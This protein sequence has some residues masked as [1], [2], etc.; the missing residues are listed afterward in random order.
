MSVPYAVPEVP[1]LRTGTHWA[2][3]YCQDD[4]LPDGLDILHFLRHSMAAKEGHDIIMPP[5]PPK[6]KNPSP[7]F[8]SLLPFHYGV[9]G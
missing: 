2:R 6:N 9:V 5:L 3:L 7:L 8:L 1:H 4:L